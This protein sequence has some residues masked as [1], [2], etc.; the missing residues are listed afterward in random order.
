[1]DTDSTNGRTPGDDR[2]EPDSLAQL[3]GDGARISFGR[4]PVT[5]PGTPSEDR[6]GP[7]V[8]PT[9]PRG[10]HVPARAARLLDG[11][12]DYGD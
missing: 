3:R 1:M 11:M 9:R 5:A 12:S 7:A 4:R 2:E 8:E 6:P 10:V